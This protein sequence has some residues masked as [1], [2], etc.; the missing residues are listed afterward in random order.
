MAKRQFLERPALIHCGDLIIDG[1][2]QKGSRDLAAV[3]APP[4]PRDGGS[5][6]SPVV[7]ELAYA[8]FQK[9]CHTLRFNFRGVEASTGVISEE[10]GA[11]DE[12]FWAALEFTIEATGIPWINAVG[13]S[14]GAF[15]AHRV[16]SRDN[17]VGKVVMIAPPIT[18]LD[19]RPLSSLSHPLLIITGQNDPFCPPDQIK[20]LL[21][22][23][24]KSVT[25]KIIPQADHNFLIGLSQVG[26]EVGE[27]IIK[28]S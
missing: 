5:M 8:L 3:I 6:S 16:A 25:L 18:L 4:L 20:P 28:K 9:E 7:L 24:G 23:L 11:G 1:L 2:Y 14:F 12:D 27:F 21:E 26:K 13:Y 15:I 22:S 10:Y 19:F 17:R